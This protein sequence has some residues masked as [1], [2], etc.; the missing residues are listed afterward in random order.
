LLCEEFGWRCKRSQ[1][2]G[3]RTGDAHRGRSPHEVA[4][5]DVTRR[6]TLVQLFQRVLDVKVVL[7]AHN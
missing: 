4:T 6:E 3:R 2:S 1:R 5:T 7:F